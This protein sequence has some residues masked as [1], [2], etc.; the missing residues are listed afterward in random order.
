MALLTKKFCS[1]NRHNLSRGFIFADLG[2]IYEIKFQW[3]FER[4]YLRNIFEKNCSLPDM[5]S[6]KIY[7]DEIKIC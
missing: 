1:L 2:V 7:L 3:N 6:R 4:P 5:F